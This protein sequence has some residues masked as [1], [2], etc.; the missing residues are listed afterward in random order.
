MSYPVWKKIRAEHLDDPTNWERTY[1]CYLHNPAAE[2]QFK[3]DIVAAAAM[4]TNDNNP[5]HYRLSYGPSSN[6]Q[7]SDARAI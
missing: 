5:Q 4:E 1:T 2:T 7:P 3:V 6:T